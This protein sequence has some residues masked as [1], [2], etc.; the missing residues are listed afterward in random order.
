MITCWLLGTGN[1]VTDH[2]Q[3]LRYLWAEINLPT[4]K[5]FLT[6]LCNNIDTLMHTGVEVSQQMKTFLWLTPGKMYFTSPRSPWTTPLPLLKSNCLSS[7]LNI[8]FLFTDGQISAASLLQTPNVLGQTFSFVS[9]DQTSIVFDC[10][11]DSLSR[12]QERNRAKDI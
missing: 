7:H 9:I 8:R 10:P 5:Q 1:N 11:L 4:T 12:L 6:G 3:K 2:G